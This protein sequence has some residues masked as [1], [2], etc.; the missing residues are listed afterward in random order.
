MNSEAQVTEGSRESVMMWRV[1]LIVFSKA[2]RAESSGIK[3][4][5]SKI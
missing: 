2:E 5:S 3:K 1:E 4:I